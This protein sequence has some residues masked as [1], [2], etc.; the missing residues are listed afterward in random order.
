[1]GASSLYQCAGHPS[2]KSSLDFFCTQEVAAPVATLYGPTFTA[3]LTVARACWLRAVGQLP[4]LWKQ[5][6]PYTAAAAVAPVADKAAKGK[7]GGAAVTA[8]VE[9]VCLER[10]AALLQ[11]CQSVGMPMVSLVTDHAHC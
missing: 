4:D 5:T 3:K 8:A 1:M 11:V 9:G 7:P 10:A 6:V 2:N